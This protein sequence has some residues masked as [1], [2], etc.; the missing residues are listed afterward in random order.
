MSMSPEDLEKK[1][2]ELK[3]AEE[4]LK[5]E[6]EEKQKK[7]KE[8]EEA[9]AKKKETEDED[10]VKKMLGDSDAILSLLESKRK[11]NAEAKEYRLKLEAIEKKLKDQEDEDL[12]KKGDHEKLAEKTKVELEDTKKKFEAKLIDD[13]ITLESIKQK[14]IDPDLAKLV[15]KDGVKVDKDFTVTGQEEA[16]ASYKKLKPEFFEPGE[17][18]L[19]PEDSKKPGLRKKILGGSEEKKSA[20]SKI[21]D[22]LQSSK[23]K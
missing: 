6:E 17:E 8:E 19:N 11:A 10:K 12:K 18:K 5:L 3:A 7:K 23:K 1:K 21:K 15:P 13:A 9:E 20:L 22:G 4:K 14:I 2:A 16:V